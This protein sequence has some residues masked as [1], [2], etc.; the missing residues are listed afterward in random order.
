MVEINGAYGEG[1]GQ[2]LRSSLTLAAITGKPLRMHHIRANRSKPGLRAQHLTAVR[3]IANITTSDVTGAALHSQTLHLTPTRLRAG[4][5]QFDIETA[6][7]LTLVLQTIFLPLSFA[8]GFSK[9]TL[10]GG[11]HVPWSPTYHY[12]ER[13]WL[14]IMTACGFRLQMGLDKAGFYPRGGGKMWIKILPP[15]QLSPFV[16]LE[17]GNLTRIRGLS[18]V[19][20]LESHIAKRQKHRALR[21]LYDT[22]Q[23]V[24]LK[25]LVMPSPGKGSFVQLEA[26]FSDGG[27][28]CYTA[29]GAPQKRAEKVADEAVSSLSTFLAG[30]GCVDE[31]LADQ[32]L[33]PLSMIPEHSQYRT[34]KITQHLL[35]NAHIIQQFLTVEIQIEGA[36]GEPGLVSVSGQNMAESV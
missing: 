30:D 9:V 31:Y 2:I 10:T 17:R 21:S 20:N 5:Y 12:L 7:A 22:S 34:H 6:G 29:L 25:T 13:H 27:R 26:A 32:L 23:D 3:A 19:A 1:G 36:L 18:G 8:D 4:R 35:T 15:K 16:C 14:P 11:T 24:K 33:L 28:G